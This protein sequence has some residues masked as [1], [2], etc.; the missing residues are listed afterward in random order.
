MVDTHPSQAASL[1][2]Q[3]KSLFQSKRYTKAAE[4]FSRAA[5]LSAQDGNALLAAE[6][7]NNQAVALL[8]AGEPRQAEESLRGTADIF[9]EAGESVKLGMALAN[10]ATALKDL[11]KPEQAVDL[12]L[13][14]ADIFRAAG[15]DE[16]YLQT[17]QSISSLKMKLRDL[18]GALFSM[19]AGLEGLEKPTWRQ[20]LLKKV[21]GIPSNLL[22][23]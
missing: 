7:R 23:R 22:N 18:T 21:L 17:M 8:M 11:G 9:Q 19:Q 20:K 14:A 15:A 6:L 12:F 16:M 2:D 1:I 3:G 13:Q 5:E 4:A 10:Q